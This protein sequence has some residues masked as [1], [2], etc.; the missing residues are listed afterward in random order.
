MVKEVSTM[1]KY[2]FSFVVDGFDVDSDDHIEALIAGC[3]LEAY[4]AFDGTRTRITFVVPA[5]DGFAALREAAD[6]L[7]LPSVP[8]LSVRTVEPDLVNSHDIANRVGRT[9][10]SVRQLADGRRGPGDFPEHLTTIG[11]GV[12]IWQWHD[13]FYWMLGNDMLSEADAELVPV[14]AAEARFFSTARQMG[15]T[16]SSWTRHLDGTANS[17][18]IADHGRVVRFSGDMQG[19]VPEASKDIGPGNF[20]TAA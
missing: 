8:G 11:K 18:T 13:V 1:T 3:D 16:W 5:E 12:R 4:P 6:A 9:A 17:R 20:A 2:T 15:R 14:S 19:S 10:S 7:D